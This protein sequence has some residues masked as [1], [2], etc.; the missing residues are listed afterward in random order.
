MSTLANQN[1]YKVAQW[2]AGRIGRSA[3]RAVIRHPAMELVALHVHSES[4]EGQDAGELCELE[5]I[6]VKATRDINAILDAKPD[7][8]L[9]MPEGYNLDDMCTLLAA[10]INIV[11]TR[12]EFFN[13]NGMDPEVVQRLDAACATGNSSIHATGSSP[14]FSSQILPLALSCLSRRIDCLTIDEFADIPA[15]TTPSMITDVMGF[16]K[17]CPENLEKELDHSTQGFAQSLTAVAEAWNLTI[18]DY[19]L[20]TEFVP[21]KTPITLAN[22]EVIEPGTCAA[23]RKTIA[24]YAAGKPVLQLRANWYCAKDVDADWE[25]GDNGWRITVEGDTPMKVDISFPD[26]T[27]NFADHMSGLTAHPA[28]NAVPFVC[29]AQPG[30]LTNLDLPPIMPRLA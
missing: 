2:A 10:G 30:I 15:S 20:F 26:T 28:V 3:M 27:G 11:T 4:K 29:A 23:Q 12:S 13:R 6:G 17:P 18:D 8:V 25:L 14:G 21:A 9:Y 1:T 16:G 19:K 5:A 22:G 7:C 24:A